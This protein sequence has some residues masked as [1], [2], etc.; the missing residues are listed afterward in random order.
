MRA[1]LDQSK[2]LSAFIMFD[3]YEHEFICI[4]NGD[5]DQIEETRA[6]LELLNSTCNR[7]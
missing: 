2:E 4:L 3:R 7:L 5:Y 1:A 6:L